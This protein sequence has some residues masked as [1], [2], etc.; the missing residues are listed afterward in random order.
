MN[1]LS[2]EN[3]SKNYGEKVL[4]QDLSIG[5]SQGQKVALVGVNGSGK[6]SLLRV[7]A[8]ID[9]PD[10][11]S[12]SIRRG[13]RME[14]LEQDPVFDDQLTVIE[15]LFQSDNPAVAAVREYESL[16]NDPKPDPVALQHAITRMDEE[17]AWDFESRI[18][19]ILGRLGIQ[20][21]DQSMTELSGGQRKRVALA[22]VLIN[23]P[24]L[25]VLDEPTNH[26]D[27]DTIEW[28]ED[29]LATSKMTLLMV[30][31][32]RYFLDRITDEILE[33]EFGN[34]YR[35]KGNY[36][37]FI[38]KKSEREAL[39]D[40]E[41]AKAQNLM[42]KE[43]DWMRR[44]PK[45][46]TTKSK[47]RIDSFYDLQDKAKN[48]RIEPKIEL[49]V[50]SARLGSKIME[51]YNVSKAYDDLTILDKFSYV[52]KRK[53]R[54]GI[55]G[56][57]GVGKTTVLNMLTGREPIDSGEI[58]TGETIV[59]G[60]YTQAGLQFKPGQRV[61]DVVKEAAEVIQTEEGSKVSASQFL[62][63]FNFPFKTQNTHVSKISGG[64]KRRLHLLRV[65]IQNP[66]FLILDE[67]TNDLDLLT[68][69][70]LEDFLLNFEGCLVIVSHDRYFMDKLVDH[71]FS[72]EG[73]G[74]IKDFPGNYSQYRE[75]K[76]EQE[77][78][79][80]RLE[81]A[82]AAAASEA[83]EETEKPRER[84]KTKL[85][86][87]EKREFEA[88]EGEIE[89]LEARKTELTELLNSGT[90]DYTALTEWGEELEQVKESLDE[91]EFRWLELSEY[92]E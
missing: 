92:A 57:N 33:L 24:Q 83:P 41:V 73:D 19:E 25:L 4:F 68:L 30:T 88:L 37:Y 87:N 67:P 36:S 52:F 64:E 89:A 70:V 61:I 31:H 18:K 58:R 35:Y 29:Y 42:R 48:R 53:E 81:A 90:T 13:I 27:L 20:A 85:T 59:F 28:L 45:A 56:P 34:L 6:S 55:V 2:A 75:W 11:G 39:Q 66:N 69:N 3:I 54:I 51:L 7:L 43:L 21:T 23:E 22:R 14:F 50:K 9:Q 47:S 76:D 65:L 44:Q 49:Q 46:R 79:Q 74:K 71:V 77:K 15:T 12:V 17:K 72:F 40:A 5:I 86:F 16:L 26:L 38:E 80:K 8:M 78:E 84:E 60:Y 1:Y 63:H 82:A 62:T 91:K 10:A 32:D